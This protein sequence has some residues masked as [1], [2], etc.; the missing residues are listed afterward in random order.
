MVNYR[1]SLVVTNIS[2]PL[3]SL[4]LIIQPH[5]RETVGCLKAIGFQPL[6]LLPQLLYQSVTSRQLAQ[7]FLQISELL[8][9]T[10]QAMSRF[11]MTR[12]LLESETLLVDFLQAQPLNAITHSV[13]YAWFL[14]IL[15]QQRL[16]FKYQ[17]IFSLDSGQVF[18]Y[19]CLVRAKDEQGK[20]LNGSQLI[21][22]G[23]STQL[24]YEFDELAR[25][26]CIESICKTKSH[27]TFLIN[28]LPNAI[29]SNPKSL[30]QNVQ[31]IL[32]LGLR[33][34]QIVFELTEVEA[35]AQSSNLPQIIKQIQE[36]GVRVAIDDLCGGVSVDHY[37]MEFRP[38]ILK[39]DKRL[40]QGCSRYPLKQILLK[41]LLE[42][43]H[44]WDVLVIAEGLED[45]EDIELCRELGVDMGQ[46]FGLAMPEVHLR[47]KPF[48]YLDFSLY[49]AS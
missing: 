4:H 10:S 47:Q 12:S 32:D 41:S 46:G 25:T 3:D 17:P 13:K 33:P 16:F 24:A 29:I 31:Q 43:A 45:M 21:E 30:E 23:L 38:D 14:K 2:S 18:A 15:A 7:I 35:L 27:Q 19:E 1:E 5:G 39:L 26:T 44:E 28:I 22:A 9:E 34:E 36:M 40:V 42:S 20:D 6:P 11:F 8:C 37:V 49:Q 48:D